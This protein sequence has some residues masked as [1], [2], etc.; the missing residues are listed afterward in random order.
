MWVKTLNQ[1]CLLILHQASNKRNTK[2]DNMIYMPLTL[3]CNQLEMRLSVDIFFLLVHRHR[4]LWL[5]TDMWFALG[6]A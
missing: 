1:T 4:K 2:S 3:P 6:E 5:R